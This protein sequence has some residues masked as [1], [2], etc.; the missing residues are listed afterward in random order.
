MKVL[1]HNVPQIVDADDSLLVLEM[2]IV[3]PPFLLDFGGADLDYRVDFPPE[4]IEEWHEEKREEF[5]AN[6]PA[7]QRVLAKMES[8]GI[9]I[10]DIHPGNIKF[11]DEDD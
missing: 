7:V 1:S 11:G 2:T 5:G 4:I 8:M 6:W 9:Y 10:R 3:Q